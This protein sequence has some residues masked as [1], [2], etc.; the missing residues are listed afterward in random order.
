MEKVERGSLVG[1]RNGFSTMPD[2][3]SARLSHAR[4]IAHMQSTYV[5]LLEDEVL[6]DE[7]RKAIIDDVKRTF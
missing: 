5:R 2:N 3:R 6:S 4:G 7:R 1:A